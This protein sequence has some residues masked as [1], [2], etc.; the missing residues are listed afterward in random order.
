VS[1]GRSWIRTLVSR[2]AGAAVVA[3]ITLA[4]L[5]VVCRIAD[6]IGISYY[7]ETARWLDTLVVREPVGYWNRPGQTGTYFGAKVRINSIGLRGPEIP[8]KAKGEI[9][10]LLMGDSFP[11]GI[12]V[13][14]DRALAAQLEAQLAGEAPPGRSYR[15]INMGV[16]SY[17]TQQ[18]LRQLQEIGLGLKPDLVLLAY[19]ANDIEPV[20]WVFEKRRGW[21][22]NAAQRSYAVSL[23]AFAARSVKYKLFGFT[24]IA[25]GDYVETSPK[26]RVVDQGLARM[27]A[28]CREAGVPFVAFLYDRLPGPQ[29]LVRRTGAR[30]GFPVLSLDPLMRVRLAGRDPRTLQNSPVDSHP[31]VDGNREWAA[32]LLGAL[33][34][35][36]L[37]PL[38]GTP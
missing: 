25:L 27:H 32:V 8:E 11:F 26:W 15:V 16:V 30:E 1:V 31:N 37:V 9:R 36:G 7:P 38:G 20:M 12:G 2:L 21:L 34:D 18:E 17:N 23:L 28:L 24:G 10:I 6:P 19:A 35:G 29:E 13:P 33:R 14:E 5:E 3:G 22:I 4:G